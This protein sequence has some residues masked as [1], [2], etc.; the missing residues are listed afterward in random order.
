MKS[1]KIVSIINVPP[2]V[3]PSHALIAL[4]LQ[5]HDELA[6]QAN[7]KMCL[8]RTFPELSDD[9]VTNLCK[10]AKR[11]A[12]G[13]QN[14]SSG[15]RAT[16]E[17]SIVSTLVRKRSASLMSSHTE[18]TFRAGYVSLAKAARMAKAHAEQQVSNVLAKIRSV[19]D[20][21]EAHLRYDAHARVLAFLV[22]FFCI[23]ASFIPVV[24]LD[25]RS[26]ARNTGRTHCARRFVFF[27]FFFCKG[28]LQN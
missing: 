14:M 9:A 26:A 24:S 16:I 10:N 1:Q 6:D 21:S 18:S 3:V 27:F 2:N 8:Q 4:R 15:A 22:F 20:A 7:L 25:V 5:I 17:S 23:G 12:K 13:I 19:T 28:V 11:I